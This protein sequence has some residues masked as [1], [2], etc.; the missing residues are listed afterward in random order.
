MSQ[1]QRSTASD[2]SP[3]AAQRASLILTI[4]AEVQADQSLVWRGYLEMTKSQR[5]YFDTLN[6]L[7]QLLIDL[8]WHDP[9]SQDGHRHGR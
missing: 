3:H 6:A 4:W 7:G 5:R 1:G 8:G 2:S 9:P